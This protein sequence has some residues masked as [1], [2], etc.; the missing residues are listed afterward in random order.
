[1][2]AMG[3]SVSLADGQA[4]VVVGNVQTGNATVYLI[5]HVMIPPSVG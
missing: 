4:A 1:V 5:D 2:D 3:D